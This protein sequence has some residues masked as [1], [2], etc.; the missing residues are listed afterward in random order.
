GLKR[1]GIHDNF[2]ELGGHSLLATR[3]VSQVRREIGVELPLRTIFEVPTVESLALYVLEQQARATTQ[4]GLE[5]L[6]AELESISEES[7]E[8]Q[9]DEVDKQTARAPSSRV[10]KTLL[11][12]APGFN[13]PIVKSEW[14]GRRK[15]NLLI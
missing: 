5:E 7:A 15:C 11:A 4:G 1:V 14:F 2:F 3:L 12:T 9:L 13:C 6:L 10:G 8:R